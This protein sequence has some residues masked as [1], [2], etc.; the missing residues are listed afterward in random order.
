MAFDYFMENKE[1]KYSFWLLVILV[2]A[3]I[4][5][6]WDFWDIPFMH[7]ELSAMSRLQF[8]SLSD[9][10]RYGVVLNDTHPAGVQVFLYYWVK[11][12]GEKEIWVK[13][14]FLLAGVASVYLVF[15]ILKLWFDSVTGLLAASMVASLQFF[16]MYSQIARPYSSGLFL[17][18]VMVYYWSR[19]FFEDAK[20]RY[21]I[22]FSVF[23]AL[24]SY[25]HHFSLLFAALVG[26]SGAFFV[27]KNQLIAYA[28]AGLGIFV[29]YIP[30]LSIFFLQVEQ[31]EMS[32]VGGW[33]A[34]PTPAFIVD[35]FSWLFHFSY[36]AVAIV[37][38]VTLFLTFTRG[39]WILITFSIKKRV[40][41]LLWFL[42]P[43]LIGYVYSVRVNPILQFSLL[44]FGAP[45]FF[46]F[47]FSFHRSLK[48]QQ[49]SVLVTLILLVNSV[50]LIFERDYYRIFYHQPYDDF[51]KVAKGEQMKQ[52]VFLI[53]N[54]IPY[55]H[56]Y[57]FDKYQIDLPYYTKRHKELTFSD[58]KDQIKSIKQSTVITQSLTGEELQLVKSFF[59][60]VVAYYHGFTFETYVLSKTEGHQEEGADQLVASYGCTEI[61]GEFSIKPNLKVYD[62][63]FKTEQLVMTP[64]MEWGFSLSMLLDTVINSR[65]VQ[66]DAQLYIT[67]IEDVGSAVLTGYVSLEKEVLYWSAA[68]FSR[69]QYDDSEEIVVYLTLD[70]QNI[71]KTPASFENIRA[72][73]QVWNNHK[74]GHFVIDSMRVTMRD[75]NAD[76]YSIYYN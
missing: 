74:Q 28:L 75:G 72:N 16:I 26:L 48:I 4:L 34:K 12:V 19:Y 56:R 21:L 71:L 2:V 20:L 7:D 8:D 70:L 51:F 73:F 76:R 10:I 29:L 46:G 33:L 36:F 15:K 3:T 50:S 31:G 68:P 24:S 52:D 25:N 58:F 11:L 55:I 32:G 37:I 53:D 59:P 17:T 47:I 63:L 42:I 23:G 22:W 60:H 65:F 49:L 13:L 1:K 5:R 41:L 69:F 30:H 40:V 6:F 9:L 44:I 61:C 39:K 35:F 43:L 18:L 38:G 14:P 67:P 66:M 45:Y 57:Y 54:A 27:K 64:E 62:S